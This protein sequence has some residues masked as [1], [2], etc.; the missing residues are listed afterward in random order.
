MSA[1]DPLELCVEALATARVHG[2]DADAPLHALASALGHEYSEHASADG[3]YRDFGPVECHYERL[4]PDEPWQGRFLVV[5]ADRLAARVRLDDLHEE[6]RRV[7][8][9]LVQL[10]PSRHGAPGTTLRAPLSGSILTA[11][12]GVAV[13]IAAPVWPVP[14]SPALPEA[15][16]RAV[17]ESL[18]YLLPLTRTERAEWL[19]DRVPDS[20]EAAGWWVALLHPLP[21]LRFQEWQRAAE[22]AGLEIWLLDRAADAA[23]WSREEWVW[24]WMW[25]V[26]SLTAPAARPHA[27]DLTRLSL[28]ALPMTVAQLR[29]LPTDWRA[30]TAAD[31]RRARTARALLSVATSYG[32]RVMG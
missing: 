31:L 23:A 21:T 30:L 19:S 22:W 12:D 7:G 11:E 26:R 27:A 32:A 13:A 8:Q 10:P 1:P 25:F 16:W 5:R 28:A 18:Q 17:C 3:M 14:E 29:G 24:R 6:L 15:R 2:M 4:G 20:A 9:T